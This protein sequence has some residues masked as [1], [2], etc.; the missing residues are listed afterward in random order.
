MADVE[1]HEAKSQLSQLLRRVSA[2]EEICITRRG[3]VIA[4]LVPPD[5]QTVRRFGTDLDGFEIPA[6]FDA[7]LPDD[8]Q[9][10]FES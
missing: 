7:P 9:A 8:I 6:D 4:R 5:G 10:S 2:G 3:D 1:V